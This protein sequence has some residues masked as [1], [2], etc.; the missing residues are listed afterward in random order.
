MNLEAATY[1]LNKNQPE[2]VQIYVCNIGEGLVSNQYVFVANLT[3]P[4]F[5][6]I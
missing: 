1:S 5:L 4:L 2:I 3:I 6:K